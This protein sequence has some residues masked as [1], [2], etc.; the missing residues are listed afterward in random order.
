MSDCGEVIH[1][2]ERCLEDLTR[3]HYNDAVSVEVIG[4]DVGAQVEARRLLLKGLS[5]DVKDRPAGAVSILLEAGPRD[6][7]ERVVHQPVNLS[8][9]RSAAGED[10]VLAIEAADGTM[11]LVKFEECWLD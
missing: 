5:L 3:R 11:T 8:V 2:W 4:R 7:V 6:H 1:E 9:K 10:E